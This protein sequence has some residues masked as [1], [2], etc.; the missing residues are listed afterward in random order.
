MESLRLYPPVTV[1]VRDLA[2]SL[3][4]EIF[5]QVGQR[6]RSKSAKK[7]VR[8]PEGTRVFLSLWWIHRH[9]DNFDEP[10]EFLPRRWVRRRPDGTW[11]ERRHPSRDGRRPPEGGSD[12]DGR[13]P[14]ADPNNMLS[15]S[16]GGRSC[17]GEK[18]AMKEGVTVLAFLIRA[19]TVELAD[20]NF[21][22][23]L[24]RSGP[25]QIPKDDIPLR[26]RER[27]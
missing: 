24:V 5:E 23:E 25:N 2:K 11:T 7:T 4:L 16:S 12:R 15:F 14:P 18:F 8:V 13:V 9:R 10:N 19:L 3:P 6:S 20:P 26:L 22:L 17:I 27:E 1:I 21:E